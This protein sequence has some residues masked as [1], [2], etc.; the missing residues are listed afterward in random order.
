MSRYTWL[1]NRHYEKLDYWAGGP[2]NGSGCSCGVTNTC[3]IKGT[4]CNCDSNDHV[5]RSDDGK[6]NRKSDLPIT[7]VII[8]DVAGYWSVK[9]KR[10]T[11]HQ[12]ECF[13]EI[14]P[15]SYLC[16][17]NCE[18]VYIAK[19]IDL[20]CHANATCLNKDGNHFCQCVK[21]FRGNGTFCQ[22]VRYSSCNRALAMN[23]YAAGNY[24]LTTKDGP[25]E[26][27]CSLSQDGRKVDTFISETANKEI[28]VSSRRAAGFNVYKMGYGSSLSSIIQVI[29]GEEIC[30][31]EV[32]LK[33]FYSRIKDYSWL[34]DRNWRKLS[35]WAGGSANDTGCACGITS[36]CSIKR[37]KC[38]CDGRS[39]VIVNDN[40]AI[41]DKSVLPITSVNIGDTGY[42]DMDKVTA[43]KKFRVWNIKCTSARDY[44]IGSKCP[45]NANCLSD[46][47]SYTCKCKDGFIGDGK[48]S[49]ANVNECLS[50]ELN[51][52]PYGC[53]NTIGSY[54]CTCPIG[55]KIQN[56]S[57]CVDV[58]ECADKSHDCHKNAACK[59]TVGS[60]SCSCRKGYIGDG[61]NCTDNN[62]A[63]CARA[64]RTNNNQMAT[65]YLKVNGTILEVKCQDNRNSILTTIA[66]KDSGKT[67]YITNYEREG[68]Y[69]RMIMYEQDFQSILKVIDGSHS[70]R[71][72]VKV[73]CRGSLIKRYSWLTNRANE[74]MSYWAGGPVNGT[75]CAC[76]ITN[77][78]D[79]ANTKCNCDAN[80]NTYRTDVG[81]VTRKSDL[82]LTSFS[83]G[84]TGSVLENKE[85]LIGDI[86]CYSDVD[87]CNETRPCHVN[88]TCNNTILS[89]QC[90]CNQGFYGNGKK[91]CLDPVQCQSLNCSTNQTC[92]NPNGTHI[93]RCKEGFQTDSRKCIDKD[94]CLSRTTN[95]CQ[96]RCINTVGGYNCSCHP[97]YKLT[98]SIDFDDNFLFTISEHS[99]ES[100][101]KALLSNKMVNNIYYLKVNGHIL[102]VR[103]INRINEFL[104]IISHKDSGRLFYV[105]GYERSGSYKKAISYAQNFQAITTVV[106]RSSR[107][108]QQV[109]VYC[110]HSLIKDFSWL[111]NRAN[112]KM[113]YWAG[114]PANGT[115]C[116]CG[117]TNT[118]AGTNTLCNCDANDY[119]YR[120]DSGY[121]TRKS[122]LPLTSVSTGDTGGS[123]EYK[124]LL[125]G[126]VECFLD[127][128]ECSNGLHQCSLNATCTNSIGSYNCQCKL[129][130]SGNGLHCID[131]DE[132]LENSHNCDSNAECFNTAGSFSCACKEGFSGN[133][134]LCQGTI[135]TAMLS[136]LTRLGA[137]A[138]LVKK[139]FLGTEACVKCYNW[140]QRGYHGGVRAS[141]QRIWSILAVKFDLNVF[142]SF[143]RFPDVDECSS[144]LHQCSLNTICTNSIGSY[145]CRCKLGFSSNA[146]KCI[147]INECLENGHNC[148]NNAECHNTAG[149]FRCACKEGFSGNGT[150]CQAIPSTSTEQPTTAPETCENL[151]CQNGATCSVTN[152]KPV[153]N[154]PAGLSGSRCTQKE[155]TVAGKITLPAVSL[156]GSAVNLSDTNVQDDLQNLSSPLAQQLVNAF[157]PELEQKLKRSNKDVERVEITSF[158]V[159]SL[160][161]DFKIILKSSAD[162]AHFQSNLSLL[163]GGTLG[164]S[165]ISNFTVSDFD[166][167]SSGS[168]CHKNAKCTNVVGYF[169]CQC[170]SGFTGNG[171]VCTENEEGYTRLAIILVVVILLILF[172]VLI[173]YAVWQRKRSKTSGK[174]H[175][176][177]FNERG[178]ALVSLDPIPLTFGNGIKTETFEMEKDQEKISEMPTSFYGRSN[179][180]DED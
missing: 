6:V 35:Y 22:D 25:V 20:N 136:A 112:M 94:E 4:S 120:S 60:F 12:L 110:R 121:I 152:G 77:K 87:E 53:N 57:T 58:D 32:S 141:F 24:A 179:V 63:S 104:T 117:I 28:H 100:C 128:D 50:A 54:L 45:Q 33:C 146:S 115:G 26:V 118:C 158:T 122:D 178:I 105:S 134:S 88:A 47:H 148:D 74:R 175:M 38:S 46:V 21:G 49:C 80:D 145:N 15:I 109:K 82:P 172:I 116:A 34:T 51:N 67:I 36:S 85:I 123:H 41:T 97:G 19:C 159:G 113:T 167:C 83:T 7:S 16:P 89:Y 1:T 130:F 79:V 52:C 155:I 168:Y 157:Q 93:C 29:D 156:H 169:N 173:V 162:I 177:Q 72:S 90:A 92:A 102:E 9:Y 127:V 147:D 11:V 37:W 59:N 75:G 68:S 62:Y 69:K 44:C 131:V 124:R 61:R 170:K 2:V 64:L 107:C 180:I 66:H 71:Q 86:E 84:D 142:A 154:C 3:H 132:C 70:C 119:T 18:Y 73:V 10:I 133:G 164:G 135:V 17:S 151:N 43:Y 125:I 23:N 166:E 174:W 144:G 101:K 13:E 126:S 76:G 163:I 27:A 8:G 65:Y 14:A 171:F 91:E 55:Y 150:R 98:P 114:G 108:Q 78:C 129:G 143:I 103:C 153:C 139:D 149:S 161:V 106:D 176:K 99:Y 30:K 48:I 40:G 111:S 5:V 140:K 138:V 81:F 39:K 95:D 165:S 96:H 160:I 31:Q 42:V 56:V 137:L